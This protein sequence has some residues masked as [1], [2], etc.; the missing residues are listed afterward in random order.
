MP[1]W[2]TNRVTITC[3][4]DDNL[5]YLRG[6]FDEDRVFNTLIP[7]PDWKTTPFPDGSLPTTVKVMDRTI[8]NGP[9][10]KQDLR[11][12]EWRIANW[13][14]KWDIHASDVELT[15]DETGLLECIFDTPWGP[16]EGIK[17]VIEDHG[18]EVK[19]H[20]DEPGMGS[21]GYL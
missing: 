14:C 8:L 4:D 7:E 16:P 12:Y 19:W 13:G 2:C 3:D 21:N 10:G 17:R 5:D 20:Y 6:L 1:N 18:C 9:D 11:G 15:C